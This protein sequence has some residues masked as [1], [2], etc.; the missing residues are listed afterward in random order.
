MYVQ[1]KYVLGYEVTVFPNDYY[2]FRTKRKINQKCVPSICN[3][4]SASICSNFECQLEVPIERLSWGTTREVFFIKIKT[5]YRKYIYNY[6]LRTVCK[7]SSAVKQLLIEKHKWNV[8]KE[9]NFTLSLKFTQQ[10][11]L[12]ID[13]SHVTKFR[14]ASSFI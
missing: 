11:I 9:Y 2:S 3:L 14:K 12:C 7:K 13:I 5:Y 6:I 8:Y 4:Q 10:L 1:K